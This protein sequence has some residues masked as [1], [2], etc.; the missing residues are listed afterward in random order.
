MVRVLSNKRLQMKRDTSSAKVSPANS[1][2][3]TV[4]LIEIPIPPPPPPGSGVVGLADLPKID[5]EPVTNEIS[6][7]I[8]IDATSITDEPPHEPNIV[9]NPTGVIDSVHE[10]PCVTKIDAAPITDEIPQVTKIETSIVDEIHEPKIVANSTEVIDPV[11]DEPSSE[12]KIEVHLGT[13][14]VSDAN[15]TQRPLQTDQSTATEGP[16]SIDQSESSSAAPMLLVPMDLTRNL[17]LPHD[18]GPDESAPQSREDISS[19]LIPN[20]ENDPLTP[21]MSSDSEH[22][23]SSETSEQMAALE[24]SSTKSSSSQN[25]ANL[26]RSASNKDTSSNEKDK[27][28][29]AHKRRESQRTLHSTDTMPSATDRLS[30]L[31]VDATPSPIAEELTDDEHSSNSKSGKKFLGKIKKAFKQAMDDMHVTRHR[32]DDEKDTKKRPE[33]ARPQSAREISSADKKGR[34][35]IA[36]FVGLFKPNSRKEKARSMNLDKESKSKKRTK[37]S[38]ANVTPSNDD[39]HRSRSTSVSPEDLKDGNRTRH[40]SLPASAM[41]KSSPVTASVKKGPVIKPMKDIKRYVITNHFTTSDWPPQPSGLW[42]DA[43]Q[44]PTNHSVARER[45]TQYIRRAQSK[46]HQS[47]Q[48]LVEQQRLVAQI[49]LS[50]WTR[51]ALHQKCQARHFVAVFD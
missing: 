50:A 31:Q 10:I 7:E 51:R 32:E 9:L 21:P 3:A 17:D 37:S 15:D 18:T 49:P 47:T 30:A 45:R 1:P 2:R 12:L 22:L 40:Q 43:L 39:Q 44:R 36:A 4:E 34:S 25:D 6:Q 29:K 11:V 41:S 46:Q 23:T 38:S 13:E 5:A 8:K 27:P 35:P 28:K 48:N 16:R 26:R 42:T 19:D 24:H 33:H 20:K 14:S